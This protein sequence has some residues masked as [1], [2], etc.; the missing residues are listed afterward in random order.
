[1][2]SPEEREKIRAGCIGKN[3]GKYVGR[4]MSRKWR[5][6]LSAA[7]KIAWE[8]RRLAQVQKPNDE[9]QNPDDRSNNVV[10]MTTVA[11]TRGVQSRVKATEG[12]ARVY[13]AHRG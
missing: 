7:Q 10:C 5:A 8:R 6:N 13:A 11:R 2:R 1:V 4:K 9:H 12:N 3:A